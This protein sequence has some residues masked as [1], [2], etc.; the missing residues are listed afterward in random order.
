[1][2]SK[3]LLLTGV[4][5]LGVIGFSRGDAAAQNLTGISLNLRSNTVTGDITVD[6]ANLTNNKVSLS[7]VVPANSTTGFNGVL[8]CGNGGA[9]GKPS[10]GIQLALVNEPEAFSNSTLIK[11]SQ[12]HAASA[13]VEIT[14]N[15]T[16]QDLQDL[17]DLYCPNENWFGIEYVPC[18]ANTAVEVADGEI[19][20][21]R[22][23]FSCTLPACET[24]GF[25]P[26]TLR[27]EVK[28]YVCTAQ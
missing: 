22:K 11:K 13:T 7:L 14:T 17:A 16:V 15:L 18:A 27:F 5:V 28:D 2:W 24:L 6:G 3:K 9:K 4:L 10:P 19:P 23:D 1:M 12:V 8:A 26:K 25:D 21:G 20:R